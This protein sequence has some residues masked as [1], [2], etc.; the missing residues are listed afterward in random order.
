[1]T[2]LQKLENEAK[3]AWRK[4]EQHGKNNPNFWREAVSDGKY[5]DLF[6]DYRIKR[7]LFIKMQQKQKET[8]GLNTIVLLLFAAVIAFFII[9]KS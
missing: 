4:I 3:E 1:M 7:N 8:D 5:K 9:L 6:D 2:P